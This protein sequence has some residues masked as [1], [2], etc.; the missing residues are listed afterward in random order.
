M[1]R[2]KIGRTA[3]VLMCAA[4][5][6]VAL[7]EATAAPATSLAAA[8]ASCLSVVRRVQVTCL[9]AVS[10]RLCGVQYRWIPFTTSCLTGGGSASGS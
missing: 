1:G 7:P 4:G 5:V 6:S 10:R 3:T 2:T 9:P 8:P